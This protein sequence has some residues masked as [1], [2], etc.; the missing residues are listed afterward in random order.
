LTA[1][2][3]PTKVASIYD[4]AARIVNIPGQ[5]T[6][7]RHRPPSEPSRSFHA[8]PSPIHRAEADHI[9]AYLR[10][11]KWLSLV[12]NGNVLLLDGFMRFMQ[13]F[14]DASDAAYGDD[15]VTCGSSEGYVFRLYMPY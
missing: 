9:I 10:D 1:K 11:H 13:V 4:R 5:L 7:N 8:Q 2:L 15:S 3:H 14:E 6:Q 12:I